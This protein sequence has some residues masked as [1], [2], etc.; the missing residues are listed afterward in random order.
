MNRRSTLRLGGLALAGGLAG[1]SALGDQPD[2]DPNTGLAADTS[3]ELEETPV[4][5]AGDVDALP[6]PPA[7][8]DSLDDAEVA[9]ATPDAD[10]TP[11]AAAFREGTTVAFAG[12]G[13]PDALRVLLAA[14]DDEYHY[15]IETIE[16]QAVEPAVAVP[17]ERVVHTIQFLR[18]GGWEG[19]LDPLGW[20]LNPRVPDCRTFVPESTFDDRFSGLGSAWIV[21]RFASGE[22][23]ASRTTA[24]RYD[25]DVWRL[26]V[27]TTTHAASGGGYAVDG[28]RRVADFPNDESLSDWFPNPH[29]RNGI[30]VSNHSDPIAER[31]D[32]S[33]APTNARAR[34]ALT[35]CC[36]VTVNGVVGYDHRTT[37]QWTNDGLLDSD[38]RYGGGTG[39]GE[40]HVRG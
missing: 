10:R 26:R 14:V 36:G 30:E 7:R 6:D 5:L 20:A 8:T 22:T 24:S 12:N 4:Y 17:R 9:L 1:C 38:S 21:G 37:F 3:A 11:L 39:R 15:G 31:L 29:E 33:F 40:W 25:G 34:A 16:G 2:V 13:A 27:R 23:Y 28:A 35:G 32:V 18:E 19:V